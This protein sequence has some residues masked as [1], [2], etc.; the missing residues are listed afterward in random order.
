[1]QKKNRRDMEMST[2]ETVVN[3][4]FYPDDASEMQNAFKQYNKITD[5][6]IIDKNI[7]GLRTRAIIVPH[8]GYVYS[9]FTANIA[10]RL[11][12]N[13]EIKNVIVIGPSHHTYLEGTSVSM[14]DDYDTPFGKL[15]I[16]QELA[17]ILITKFHLQFLPQAHNE[18]STEVQ[19]PF[20]K[21]YLPDCLV[22]EL[23][24][25]KENPN[26]L[27]KVIDFILD[28]P[29]NA[30]VISTDLSH[31]HNINKA[32]ALDSLCI[33]A[34]EELDAKKLHIGC[35][36]CGKIG[37]EAM[38]LSAKKRELKPTLLDYRTSAD[39]NGDKTQVVGYVSVAFV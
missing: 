3:G 29:Q 31:Y 22:V 30:V 15:K 5:K 33:K 9:G 1:M 26:N 13:S 2:R 18:H 38:L 34:I 7:L 36:A 25:G 28:D 39:A 19:M 10:M 6:N 23:I 21:Y 35:E 8:A 12:K 14:Y 32:N 4:Q 27:S 11:L 20:I 37:V 16:N 24:Y 17:Q